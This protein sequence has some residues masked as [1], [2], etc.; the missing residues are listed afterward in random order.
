MKV[1]QTAVDQETDEVITDAKADTLPTADV[2]NSI[3]H[4]SGVTKQG[5]TS[6]MKN[7]FTHTTC[8]KKIQIS[9]T[10]V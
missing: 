5:K 9:G 1:E 8:R 3:S 10:P 2:K 7:C 6:Y 4:E